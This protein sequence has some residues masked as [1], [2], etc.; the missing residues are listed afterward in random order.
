[1][2]KRTLGHALGLFGIFVIYA[3]GGNEVTEGP[4]HRFSI[5]LYTRKEVSRLPRDS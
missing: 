5:G 3:P 1:M 2:V 4:C